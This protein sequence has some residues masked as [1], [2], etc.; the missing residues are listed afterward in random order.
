LEN[1]Q[2][3]APIVALFRKLA[4]RA[5]TL[6]EKSQQQ[7]ALRVGVPVR[8]FFQCVSRLSLRVLK[9]SNA[10]QTD[11]DPLSSWLDIFGHMND[12]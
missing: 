2:E 9:D 7:V 5:C 4:Q 12:G 3:A 10:E 1:Q 11:A 8:A 6:P